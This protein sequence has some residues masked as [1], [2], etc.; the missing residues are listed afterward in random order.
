MLFEGN[1]PL[2]ASGAIASIML[3]AVAMKWKDLAILSPNLSGTAVKI[4]TDAK[5]WVGIVVMIFIIL[6]LMAITKNVG[7][8]FIALRRNADSAITNTGRIVWNFDQAARGDAYFLNMNRLNDQEIRIIGFGA[9]GRNNSRDPISEFSGF[10]RSDLTNAQLPIYL[11]EQENDTPGRPNFMPP[12][13]VPTLPQETFG[14]PPLADF[15][16]VTHNKP[17]IE[18]GKDGVTIQKFLNEFGS[19][20]V[21]LKYD[22][23]AIERHFST[24]EIKKQIS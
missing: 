5:L 21:V 1:L 16:I 17:Y 2:A 24:E 20:T 22:G 8:S 12:L 11:L 15:D 14:I 23:T 13:V 19:F 9:H 7:Q 4:A 6:N 10:M 3:T 18:S